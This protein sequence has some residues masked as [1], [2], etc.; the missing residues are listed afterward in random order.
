MAIAQDRVLRI[1]GDEQHLEVGTRHA[2]RIRHLSPVH[3]A[4]QAD[5]RHQQVDAHVR[6]Q[7]PETGCAVARLERGVAEIVEDVGDQHAHDG[8]V[9]HDQHGFALLGSRQRIGLRLSPIGSDL[10]IVPGQVDR[11]GGARADFGIDP[12]LPAR[13]LGEAIDHRQAE[14]GALADRFRCE[15]RLEHPRDHLRR[16]AGAGVGHGNRQVLPRRHVVRARRPL[17]QPLVGGLDGD[18]T[19]VRHRVA[20]VDAQVEQ[21]VLELRGIDQRGP[22]AGRSDNLDRDAGADRALDQL[23]HAGDQPVHVRRFGIKG[24]PARKGEEAVGEGRRAPRRA[25][26]GDHVA[27]DVLETPLFDAHLHQFERAGDAGQQ[28]VEVVRQAAGELAHGFHLLRLAKEFLGFLP[29]HHL[30]FE[31]PGP[32]ADALLERGVQLVQGVVEAVGIGKRLGELGPGCVE[33]GR[34]AF[35]LIEGLRR[36]RRD[37]ARDDDI[38]LGVEQAGEEEEAECPQVD[39]EFPRDAAQHQQDGV[40]TIVVEGG[41]RHHPLPVWEGHGAGPARPRREVPLE[42]GSPRRTSR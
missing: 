18:A 16:H 8:L 4:G 19:A 36:R 39:R 11:D 32:L 26:G 35:G 2:T 13:L 29:L 22:E 12:H 17:I 40:T 21:R 38:V 31:L 6:L 10:A 23:L 41:E 3:A 33:R 28:V 30:G 5:I 15:E 24:L 27:V 34:E 9:V 42:Q 14:A 7:H 37:P 20:G 25:L 1:A